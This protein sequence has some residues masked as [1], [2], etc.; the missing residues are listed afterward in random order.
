MVPSIRYVGSREKSRALAVMA[1]AEKKP[2]IA[3]FFIRMAHLSQA[4]HEAQRRTTTIAAKRRSNDWLHY[5]QRNKP[6]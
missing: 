5:A 1:T 3:P 2:R 6:A 4:A